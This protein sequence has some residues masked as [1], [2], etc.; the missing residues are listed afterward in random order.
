M[1]Q[2]E[3]VKIKWW[4][5]KMLLS[6]AAVGVVFGIIFFSIAKNSEPQEGVKL[7]KLPPLHGIYKCCDAG[8]RYSQSWVGSTAVNCIGLSYYQV[9]TGRNDCGL[10]EQLN[11]RPVEAIQT[12]IPTYHGKSPIV[13]EII[14]GSTTYYSR[15]DDE[16]REQWARESKSN[17]IVLG[18]ISFLIFHF[19]QLIIASKKANREKS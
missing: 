2:A 1:S 5:K 11:G 13:T 19:I 16:I 12:L 3:P 8:G 6:S 18:F 4:N 15:N 10:K 9:G 17:S 14:S 7:E